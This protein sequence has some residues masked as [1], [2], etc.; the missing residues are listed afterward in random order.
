MADAADFEHAAEELRR[1]AA[2]HIRYP[3]LCFAAT[4][5]LIVT[6]FCVPMDSFAPSRKLRVWHHPPPPRPPN[7]PPPPPPPPDSFVASPALVHFMVTLGFSKEEATRAVT[8][9]RSASEAEV[10]SKAQPWSLTQRVEANKAE[11]AVER[12]L[13]FFDHMD[14]DGYALR[15]GS[16]NIASSF[17][18]C[19]K[20]CMNYKPEKG[21]Y[22][23]PCNIFVYCPLELCFAPAQLPKGSRLGWCWLKNQPLGS[24]D[25]VAPHVNMNGTDRRTKTGFVEWQA[26][27]VARK[28]VAVRTDTRSARAGW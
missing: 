27:V 7:P 15:W 9:T 12:E 17:E 11:F 28:G 14:M 6:F 26:G 22:Y 16:D 18:D 23:M 5:F 4:S 21:L 24:A 20:R 1:T 3:W 2:Q 13:H 10:H 19:G 8:A 25:T